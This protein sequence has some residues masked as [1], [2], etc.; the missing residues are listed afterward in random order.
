M[1]RRECGL[2]MASLWVLP[3]RAC[4]ILCGLAEMPILWWCSLANQKRT[5]ARILPG[6]DSRGWSL[7]DQEERFLTSIYLAVAT[8][9]SR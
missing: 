5:V 7:T 2:Q 1:L 3:D 4:G 8:L 9:V 6:N